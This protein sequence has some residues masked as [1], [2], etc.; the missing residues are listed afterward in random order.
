MP[1]WFKGFERLPAYSLSGRI[2]RDQAREFCFKI[3]QFLVEAVVLAI[4]YRRRSFFIVA[5]IMLFNF[6]S[7]LGDTFCGLRLIL[8]HVA[9]YKRLKHRQSPYDCHSET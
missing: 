6:A 5:A 7:Q 1:D 9:R 4:A 3:N 2:G 8:R